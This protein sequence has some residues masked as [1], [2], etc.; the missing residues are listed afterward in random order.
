MENAKSSDL[1]SLELILIWAPQFF[2]TRVVREMLHKRRNT[3]TMVK[4]VHLALVYIEKQRESCAVECK[5]AIPYFNLSAMFLKCSVML[6]RHWKKCETWAQ[7][8][9]LGH[10]YLDK[11][12]KSIVEC[13]NMLFV[14]G[15]QKCFVFIKSLT[16]FNL[17]AMCG[18]CGNF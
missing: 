16:Y 11:Q 2:R 12:W 1:R 15:I 18:K 6:E 17:V 8:I 4:D 5:N 7:W 13:K 14:N 10:V 3:S 9:R